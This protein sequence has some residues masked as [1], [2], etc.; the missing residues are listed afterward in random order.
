MS[1]SG[2]LLVLLLHTLGTSRLT[3]SSPPVQKGAGAALFH[4]LDISEEPSFVVLTPIAALTWCLR[5]TVSCVA[6]V[7]F[8]RCSL[9]E[10]IEEVRQCAGE[11][12]L[13]GPDDNFD[14][15]VT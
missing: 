11:S 15:T 14:I 9:E 10:K 3:A 4:L 5:G 6:T 1:A 8:W 13:T 2:C 7:E 12:L